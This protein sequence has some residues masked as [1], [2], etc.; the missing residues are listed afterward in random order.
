MKKNIFVAGLPRSG[1][2]LISCILGQHTSIQQMGESMYAGILNPQ[3]TMCSCGLLPCPVSQKI[4]ELT[5]SAPLINKINETYGLIDKLREPSKIPSSDTIQ[6]YSET[7][8][9]T[10]EAKIRE[11][12]DA[13]DLL[14]RIYSIVFGDYSFIDNSKEI[15]FAEILASRSNWKIILVLRDPRG[16]AYSVKNAGKRKNV[17]RNISQKIPVFI[18]FASRAIKLKN[19]SNALLLRYEDLCASPQQ[20]IIKM[21]NFL[22]V[23]FEKNMLHFKHDKGHTLSGNRMRLDNNEIIK[24]DLSWKTE[25]TATEISLISDNTLLVNLYRSLGYSLL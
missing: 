17:P 1:T 11:S 21:C 10:I 4:F 3:D 22:N 24:E 13:L 12:C 8:E 25:L 15:R 19:H 7:D 9:R 5:S 18:D 23:P 16:I 20:S 14:T 6:N 2:T